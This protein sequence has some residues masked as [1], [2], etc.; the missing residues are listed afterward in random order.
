MKAASDRKKA[1][2]MPKT[3][4]LAERAIVLAAGGCAL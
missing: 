4:Y 3:P 2:I 1:K